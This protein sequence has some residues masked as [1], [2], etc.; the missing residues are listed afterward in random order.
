MSSR[1]P[2]IRHAFGS[3]VYLD[4]Q[5]R[6]RLAIRAAFR[7]AA[8]GIAV[9]VFILCAA[10]SY[11]AGGSILLCLTRAGFAGLA[12]FILLRLVGRAAANYCRHRG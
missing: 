7:V 12:A 11:E 4:S 9:L 2:R 3:D 8:P 1:P 5:L 10:S 6:K